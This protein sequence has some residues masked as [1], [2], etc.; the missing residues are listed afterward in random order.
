MI[1]IMVHAFLPDDKPAGSSSGGFCKPRLLFIR[2]AISG[3]REIKSVWCSRRDQ[4]RV[5]RGGRHNQKKG[6]EERGT[7]RAE[8][9]VLLV[10][11]Q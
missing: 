7:V 3:E 5:S 9:Q 2:E 4:M 6:T 10:Y 8:E 1:Y 11:D